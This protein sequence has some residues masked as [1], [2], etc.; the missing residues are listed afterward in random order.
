MNATLK[1][2]RGGVSA[3]WAKCDLPVVPVKLVFQQILTGR[4][5]SCDKHPAYCEDLN[6]CRCVAFAPAN[7]INAMVYFKPGK[8]MR[9]MYFSVSDTGKLSYIGISPPPRGMYLCSFYRGLPL[10]TLMSRSP[11]RCERICAFRAG[12][13]NI[14]LG[15]CTFVAFIGAYPWEL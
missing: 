15:V 12:V 10:G 4:V 3:A 6:V 14:S 1:E 8:Y 9:M 7:R 11:H 5:G 13:Y 2:G